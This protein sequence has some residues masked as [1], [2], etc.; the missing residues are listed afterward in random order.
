MLVRRLA[1]TF[2]G[3]G[4]KPT[5]SDG[6][7]QEELPALASMDPLPLAALLQLLVGVESLRLLGETTTAA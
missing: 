3:E 5:K 7:A 6:S 2:V 4:E 1:A